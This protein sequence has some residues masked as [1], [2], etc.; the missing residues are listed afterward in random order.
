MAAETGATSL[1]RRSIMALAATAAIAAPARAQPRARRPLTVRTLPAQT[2]WT[3]EPVQAPATEGLAD[4]PGAKLFYRDTG[5]SGEPVILLHASTGSAL[6]WVYQQPVLARAGYRVIS[7]SRRSHYRSESGDPAN[8]GTAVD[9]LHNLIQFLRLGDRRVHLLGTAYGG[10]TP[11]D[12]VLTHPD[13]VASIT[14]SNTLGGMQEPEFNAKQAAILPP[15]WQGLPADFRELSGAYR[16]MNP[17]GRKRWLELEHIAFKA[18]QIRPPNR[19]PMTWANLERIRTPAL[20]MTGDADL[21]QPPPLM[22]EYASH[23]QNVEACVLSECGHS[24]YWE[25]P[26]AFNATLIAFLRKH[27]A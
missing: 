12:Y 14:L 19:N 17:E 25:Q 18:P 13:K 10:Y 2:R 21:Y 7:Y 26:D 24:A 9:D 4:I 11:T 5:G 8:M 22:R 23:L 27:R 1:S 6:S 20:V 15:G 16:A 3:A